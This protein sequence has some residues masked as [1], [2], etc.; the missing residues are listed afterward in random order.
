M[1]I[2]LI[3]EWVGLAA[4][5]PEGESYNQL[6]AH[7]APQLCCFAVLRLF[8]FFTSESKLSSFRN[9]KPTAFAVGI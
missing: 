2:E 4:L 6:N 5:I 9:K 1:D 7:T 8:Y 3:A